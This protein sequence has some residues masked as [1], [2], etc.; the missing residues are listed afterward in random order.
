MLERLR[1]DLRAATHRPAPLRVARLAGI[2]GVTGNA[3][4][5]LGVERSFSSKLSSD[6]GGKNG[7]KFAPAKNFQPPLNIGSVAG[8]EP[9]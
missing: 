7:F 3:S 1:L 5:Y 4:I 9:L 8:S 6:G 2:V